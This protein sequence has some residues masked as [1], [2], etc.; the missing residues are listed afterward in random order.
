M[1]R[2]NRPVA[3]HWQRMPAATL[4]NGAGIIPAQGTYYTV[5]DTVRNVVLKSVAQK[6]KKDEAVAQQTGNRITI[7]GIA[8]TRDT[9]HT[10][11]NTWDTIAISAISDSAVLTGG[12]GLPLFSRYAGIFCKSL[13]VEARTNAA[14]GTNPLLFCSVQYEQ[15]RRVVK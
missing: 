11:D 8:I 1:M 14:V 12:L 5:L 9:T 7:D 6:Y 2:E 15:L 3:W 4:G 10:A 13:K